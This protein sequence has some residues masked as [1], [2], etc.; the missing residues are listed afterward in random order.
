MSFLHQRSKGLGLV[1]SAI[2]V[3]FFAIGIAS[4]IYLSN[5]A[6]RE[7][8]NL[9][10]KA[11]KVNRHAINLA[12]ALISSEN[13]TYEDDGKIYRG[14]LDADKLE[15]NL[16]KIDLL[17]PDSEATISV[18]DL[19]DCGL[20]GCRSWSATISSESSILSGVI[21]IPVKNTMP[22]TGLPVLIRYSDGKLDIGKINVDIKE[23]L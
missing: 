13:M 10:M 11:T 9:M 21:T 12:N 5:S 19:E 6:Q 8:I 20:L 2:L 1:I 16:G 14:I 22:S 23:W 4:L 15:K 17:Y 3:S 7:Q 18:T